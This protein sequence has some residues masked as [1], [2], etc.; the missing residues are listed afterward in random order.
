[1]SLE[2]CTFKNTKSLNELIVPGEYKAKV[3]KV[4]DGDTVWVAYKNE[5]IGLIKAKVR[6]NRIDAPEM[7]GY[8]GEPVADANA[9]KTAALESKHVVESLIDGKIITLRITSLDQ[10]SRILGDI[11]VDKKDWPT[12]IPSYTEEKYVDLS[13]FMLLGGYAVEY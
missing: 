12:S 13:T 7:K 1:M 9:R 6:F 11:I 10:Y 2:K 3:L 8:K 4:H 5:T